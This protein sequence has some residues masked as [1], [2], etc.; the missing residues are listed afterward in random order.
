MKQK[1]LLERKGSSLSNTNQ[2]KDPVGFRALRALCSNPKSAAFCAKNW[3]VASGGKRWIFQG[4][5]DPSPQMS[6]FLHFPLRRLQTSKSPP[7][8]AVEAK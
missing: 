5:E 6:K 4:S 2:R 1:A 3:R 7:F 8:L